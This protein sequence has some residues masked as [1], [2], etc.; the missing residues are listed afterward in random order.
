MILSKEEVVSTHHC[1]PTRFLYSITH[2]HLPLFVS[3]SSSFKKK[4]LY[5]LQRK[6]GVVISKIG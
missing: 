2:S 5:S 1:Q 3:I 6:D 4:K